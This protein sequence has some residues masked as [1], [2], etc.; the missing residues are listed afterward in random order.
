MQPPFQPAPMALSPR[1]KRLGF[2]TDHSPPANPAVKNDS[3]YTYSGTNATIFGKCLCICC[4]IVERNGSV[5]W[6]YFIV[7]SIQ[8]QKIKK[9]I[10]NFTIQSLIL[11]SLPKEFRLF[12]TF[13]RT[14]A[15]HKRLNTC[16]VLILKHQY[17]SQSNKFWHKPTKIFQFI[18][19]RTCFICKQRSQKL[20]AVNQS[21]RKL[22]IQRM[23]LEASIKNN[24]ERV[25]FIIHKHL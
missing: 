18:L 25:L 10:R 9:K 3:N 2:E 23:Y 4:I 20:T 21:L 16:H 17:R 6:Y 12:S 11:V 22:F 5:V 14:D 24:F 1:L 7:P 13:L 15:T 8:A 19:E